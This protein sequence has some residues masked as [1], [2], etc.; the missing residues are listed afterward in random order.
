M[1]ANGCSVRRGGNEILK[2]RVCLQRASGEHTRLCW[3]GNYRF[4]TKTARSATTQWQ[5]STRRKPDQTAATLTEHLSRRWI[6]CA[7]IREG[8]RLWNKIFKRLLLAGKGSVVQ[9]KMYNW[10][11]LY[12]CNWSN[13]I[14]MWR[15]SISISNSTPARYLVWGNQPTLNGEIS[16]NFEVAIEWIILSQMYIYKIMLMWLKNYPNSKVLASS[17]IFHFPY[18]KATKLINIKYILSFTFYSGENIPCDQIWLNCKYMGGV[19]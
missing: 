8:K 18:I 16:H 14:M 19:L 10:T 9:L 17:N 6:V 4:R 12:T 3:F 7:H 2:A 13:W 1:S 5:V 15:K 11:S